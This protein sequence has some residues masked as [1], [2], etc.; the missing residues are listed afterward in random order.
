MDIYPDERGSDSG[1]ARLQETPAKMV[2]QEPGVGSSAVSDPLYENYLPPMPMP[3]RE[4][5]PELYH[6]APDPSRAQDPK[7]RKKKL[8]LGI[9][10]GVVLIGG[11]VTFLPGGLLSS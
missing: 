7:D 2:V 10:A 5:E 3:V 9:A 8:V 6:L 11:A 1:G 4:P